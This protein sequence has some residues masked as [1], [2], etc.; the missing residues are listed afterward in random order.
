M[1]LT[2]NTNV[3][4]LTAQRNLSKSSNKLNTS[5]ERLSSGLR[6][7]S[8]KDDAAGL[9]ISE[10]MTSQIRGLNQA[11]R[12]AGDGI[13][14]AQTAEGAMQ[15]STN[16]IQ[17]I[18]ELAVQSANATN[19]VSDRNAL[20]AEVNQLKQEIDRIADTTAF[21]NQK[22]LDGTFFDKQFQVG[23]NAGETITV[24]ID[25]MKATD[26][27]LYKMTALNDRFDHQGT[28]G[29]AAAF[30]S[31]E[32]Q[33]G[34]NIPGVNT[35][36][37]QNV[38]INGYRGST[39]INI[40]RPDSS[41]AY[42]IADMINAKSDETGVTAD[43]ASEM[44]IGRLTD[45]GNVSMEI[46]LGGNQVTVSANVTTSDL[47]NLAKAINEVSDQTN[48]TATV[49]GSTITMYESD[50]EDLVIGNFTHHD[51]SGASIYA[52]GAADP[53]IFS[54]GAVR[55]ISGD[56]DSCRV[57]GYVELYSEKTFTAYSDISG[58]TIFN[59]NAGEIKT[60]DEQT[61]SSIDISSVEGASDAM[62]ICDA[63]LGQI[64]SQRADLGAVQNHFESTISNLQN[65][66]ENVSAARSRILDA[67]IAKES[68]QMTK[69]SILQQAG[70]S[71][72][73]Q[74]NSQPELILKLLT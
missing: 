14:L 16:I 69:Q 20:Q 63:A 29:I 41:K 3:P 8:A 11:V 42:Q 30:I 55:L 4:S 65:I 64:D 73:S 58:S 62:M 45:D 17:R 26:L 44:V 1:S 27:G 72:L 23:A 60:P 10:R 31:G 6:I 61:V 54:V 43:A 24:S 48:V 28:G 37:T 71:V 25:S 66:V 35:I 12:N 2:I 46:G 50:G 22:I 67:D 70:T 36:A 40:V 33:G 5:L 13:S 47:S 19:S 32:F 38:T 39:V 53:D 74:A 15:E 21:N 18:R 9:A 51:V 59:V 68:S 34:Y 49:S 57:A 7:N 56:R 52:T